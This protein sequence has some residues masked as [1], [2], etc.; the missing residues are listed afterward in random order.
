M[1]VTGGERARR[2][3][4][5]ALAG[6]AGAAGLRTALLECDLARPRLAAELGL[7]AGAG[8]A[9]VPALGGDRRRRSCSR[10]RSPAR[11]RGGRRRPAGLRR[12]RR[13][14]R[15]TRRRCSACRASATW[16]RNCA[17]AY[18]LVV[19][20]R[21]AARGGDRRRSSAVA[22]Q[23]DALARVRLARRSARGRRRPRRC[24]PRCGGCRSRRSAPSSSASEAELRGRSGR[25]RRR[26]ARCPRRSG[27]RAAGRLASGGSPARRQRSTP[28]AS[29]TAAIDEGDDRHQVGGEVEAGALRQRQHL[30]AVLGDQRVLDLRPCSCPS[31]TS[32]ATKTFSRRACGDSASSS[33]VPQTGH[34]T[35]EEISRQRGLRRRGRARAGAARRAAQRQRRAARRARGAAL[36]TVPPGSSGAT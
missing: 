13:G 19:A 14:R 18:D 33:R 27:P 8:P 5:V 20:R 15:P 25:G 6:A 7:G 35:S 17:R 21:A 31:A 10:W 29:A 22:A 28:S 26:A 2:G 32:R 16:P 12:R 30:V 4:G 34:I 23:A 24:G 3:A 36:T 9:R 1:L 11:R